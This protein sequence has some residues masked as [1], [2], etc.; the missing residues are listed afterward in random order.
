MT[1]VAERNGPR[2]G[3]K[4]DVGDEIVRAEATHVIICEFKNI[5]DNRYRRVHRE[6]AVRC[7]ADISRARKYY[8]SYIIRVR[9]PRIS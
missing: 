5:F 6:A 9:T 2:L 3:V 4:T 8:F 7:P 1:R